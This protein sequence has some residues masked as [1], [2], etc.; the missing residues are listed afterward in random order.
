MTNSGTNS[1]RSEPEENARGC[2]RGTI[3]FGPLISKTQEWPG[4]RSINKN[5][6]ALHPIATNFDDGKRLLE[7]VAYDC[8]VL[9]IMGVH[10]WDLL[11]IA[12]ERGVPALM[13]TAHALTEESLHKA[14]RDGA[15]YFA[16]KELIGDI[17]AF[18]ADVLEAEEERKNPWRRW[19]E[20][21][22]SFYDKRFAGT[23]WR[24]KEKEFWEKKLK[25]FSGM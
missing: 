12:R 18:L 9:D 15:S 21:L 2:T 14:A 25:N 24:E 10:G 23:S 13:L 6:I 5:R 22:G 1:G 3:T 11:G 4:L 20:R 17:E 8:A 16:P 7:T 19:F